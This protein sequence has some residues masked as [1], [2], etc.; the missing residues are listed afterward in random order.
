MIAPNREVLDMV[1]T[2]GSGSPYGIEWK[3]RT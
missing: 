3:L 2:G 1:D